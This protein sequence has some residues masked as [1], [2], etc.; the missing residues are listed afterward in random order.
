M[1]IRS[2]WGRYDGA[3][4]GDA[5]KCKNRV[6][7]DQG[8]GNY[9]QPGVK[10]GYAIKV[11]YYKVREE[12]MFLTEPIIKDD[13]NGFVLHVRPYIGEVM[14]VFFPQPQGHPVG[15]TVGERDNY[16]SDDNKSFFS[17]SDD[18][19]STGNFYNDNMRS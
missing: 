9:H 14:E 2:D 3:K 6:R 10:F 5:Y 19:G 18:N 16:S 7:I 4:N 17:S 12:T 15:E 13:W 11:T 8:I 1:P